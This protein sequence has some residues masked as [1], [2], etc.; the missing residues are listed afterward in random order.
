MNRLK[1]LFCLMG[2]LTAGIT[3]A[4]AVT[5]TFSDF[6]STGGLTLNGNAV[7]N[8]NNGIDANPVLRLVPAT[9]GQSGSAFSS[10]TINAANFSTFFQFR[11]T[12]PGGIHDGTD[13]GADGL[14]FVI[15]PV[16][17]SIG[18]AGGGIGYQGIN[19]SVGVEFDT[20]QNGFD[21]NSNHVGVDTNGNVDSIAQGGT[22]AVAPRFDDGN[23]WS[24][25]IDYNGGILEVRAN[26][27]GIRPLSALL[28]QT[29]D[30]ST[31][32]GQPTAFVGFTAGTGSAYGNHDI[33]QWEYRDNFNPIGGAPIPEPATILLLGSGLVGLA[34][35]RYGK[36]QKV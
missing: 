23:L 7:G 29:I 19:P 6:S 2:L 4:G 5:V 18:G 8:L 3:E 10:T 11:I 22:V 36:S 34:A 25:W 24:A 28:S 20:W 27:T 32:I 30:I 33:I 35:W 9:T 26:Q 14:V 31:I 21:P 15:Q 1:T 16:S 13:T 17:S 12:N